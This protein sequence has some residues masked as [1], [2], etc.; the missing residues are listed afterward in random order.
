M[1]NERVNREIAGFT[2]HYSNGE[3][4]PM[5]HLEDTACLLLVERAS[6][7]EVRGHGSDDGMIRTLDAFFNKHPELLTNVIAFRAKVIMIGK[8]DEGATH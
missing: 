5:E 7:V 1:G 4:E 3:H 8:K 2:V 6:G